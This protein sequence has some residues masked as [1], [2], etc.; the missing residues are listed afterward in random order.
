MSG[1]D[2]RQGHR[3]EF[4]NGI[5]VCLMAIDG[6]WRRNCKLLNVSDTG[7]QL[8]VHDSVEGLNLKEFFLLLSF[9]GLAYR[10]CELAWVNGDQIGASFVTST[11]RMSGK[12]DKASA[13]ERKQSGA[14]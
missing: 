14:L 12:L 8:A 5:D 3:V 13:L 6:T 11:K 7:A 2:R 9:T 4:E 1:A 10:R